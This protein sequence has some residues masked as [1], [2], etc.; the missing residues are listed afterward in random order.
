MREGALLKYPSLRPTV[1]VGFKRETGIGY[2]G[3]AE[4]ELFPHTHEGGRS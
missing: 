1:V 4:C 2:A 3:Q